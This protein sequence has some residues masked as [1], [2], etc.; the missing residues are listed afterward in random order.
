[1]TNMFVFAALSGCA[2]CGRQ[3]GMRLNPAMSS[4]AMVALFARLRRKAV[5]A[6][7]G[8]RP[9]LH[10]LWSGPP[11]AIPTQESEV[12]R[13]KSCEKVFAYHC[14]TRGSVAK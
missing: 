5:C 3:A 9:D 11:N 14:Q 1:M 6:E 12:A 4:Q 8:Y 10:P 13:W 2:R 7:C